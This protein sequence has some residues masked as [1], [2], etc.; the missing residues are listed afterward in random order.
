MQKVVQLCKKVNIFQPTSSKQISPKK[1]DNEYIHLSFVFQTKE[2]INDKI[3]N[4]IIVKH[5]THQ[6]FQT[7]VHF[8]R[9]I[10]THTKIQTLAHFLAMAKRLKYG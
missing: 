1:E 5:L 4:I 3:S 9:N 7:K 2:F 10:D 8:M 6:Y